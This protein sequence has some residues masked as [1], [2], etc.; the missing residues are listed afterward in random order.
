M[1]G[2]FAETG[3]KKVLVQIQKDE[4]KK[5]QGL[6]DK[7]QERRRNENK[8]RAKQLGVPVTFYYVDIG[9]VF[10]EGHGGQAKSKPGLNQHSSPALSHFCMNHA[11]FLLHIRY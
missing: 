10:A 7:V 2:K 5:D 3:L 8:M 9:H 1:G 6:C 4:K 11:T